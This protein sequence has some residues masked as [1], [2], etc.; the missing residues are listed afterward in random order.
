[1]LSHHFPLQVISLTDTKNV[2]ITTF[3]TIQKKIHDWKIG[4]NAFQES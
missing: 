2:H 4:Q 1:M 3:Q